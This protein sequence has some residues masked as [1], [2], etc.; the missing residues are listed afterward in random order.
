MGVSPRSYL[1]PHQSF[2]PAPP[3]EIWLRPREFSS[4]GKNFN[5]AK[6]FIQ[7]KENSLVFL[8]KEEVKKDEVDQSGVQQSIKLIK[9]EISVYYWNFQLDVDIKYFSF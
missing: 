2:L 5:D 6:Y 9:K 7:D 4:I 3:T 1:Q 8:L